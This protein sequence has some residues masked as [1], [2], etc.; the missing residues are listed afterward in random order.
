MSHN[1]FIGNLLDL[2]DQNI[3][4]FKN[5]YSEKII[6]DVN[7]KIIHAKL[8]YK[9]VA[10]YKCGS[11]FDKDIIKHG[12]KDSNIKLLNTAG[13]PTILNLKKQRYLCR[14][15]NSTFVL[16]T[17]LVNKNCF[18]SNKVKLSIAINAQDKISEK[19]IAKHHNVS[20][21]TV[22][23]QIAGAYNSY[24]LKK[25]Y[26]PQNL[27]FDEFKSVKEA[28]GAMSF[29]YVNADTGEIVDIVEN[30]R[31]EYLRRYFLGFTKQ[32]RRAVKNIVIDMYA[33][34]MS[35]IKALFP[36]ANIIIDKFHVVQLISRA[37]N[38][39]RI[40]IMNKS[41]KHYKE[42][43]KYWKLI[44]KDR[45]NLD[46]V[47]LRYH[48]LL[49]KQMREIDI[50]DYLISTNPELEV[51]YNLYQDLKTAIKLR[52]TTLLEIVISNK[53]PLISDYMKTAQKTLRKYKSYVV[54]MLQSTYTNGV[55]EGI[56]NKIK[57]IKRIAFGYRSFRNFKNRILITQG[58]LKLK[59]A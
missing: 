56:N 43:K 9:P 51:N 3:T 6:K 48:R 39:T 15:C 26:L 7:H 12:S 30:R 44:L 49:K 17:N 45:D 35:L 23:R 24:N 8:D 36:N 10:C 34:Y 32:A 42:Y 57:V 58:M 53:D 31:L 27:N 13:H 1:D 50:V 46:T 16:R 18:I 19:D 21:S 54:N 5:Y 55:I 37:L 20:H 52:S 25:N 47:K 4:F 14:H 59:A 2:K 29:L 33:P 22:N 41:E 38:K 28:S 11:V 40:G